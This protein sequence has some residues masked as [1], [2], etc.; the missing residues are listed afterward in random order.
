M[1]ISLGAVLGLALYVLVLRL[2]IAP[3]LVVA[4]TFLLIALAVARQGRKLYMHPQGTLRHD[5]CS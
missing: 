4:I 1:P 3:P 2:D 5:G